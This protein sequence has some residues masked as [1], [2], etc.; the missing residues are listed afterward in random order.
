MINKIKKYFP[1]FLKKFLFYLYVTAVFIFRK[2]PAN[3]TIGLNLADAFTMSPQFIIGGRVK[4]LHL[5][6][7]F[8]DSK[9]KF[10]LLY[11]V[12]SVLSPYT[13]IWLKICKLFGVKVIWNQNGVAFPAWSGD[14]YE[15][16][17]HD[18]KKIH[19]ADFVIYQSEFCKLGADKYLGEYK[20]EYTVIHNCIDAEI[21]KPAERPL[22]LS[23]LVLLAIGTHMDKGRIILPLQ[24]TALLREKQIPVRLRIAGRFTWP[25][26]EAETIAEIKKLGIADLVDF[27]NQGF[28][29][30]Q[31]PAIYQSGHI[32]LHVKY[33]DPC[34]TAV[35]EAMGC[36]IPVIGSKTGGLPEL[37][38]DRA[39]VLINLPDS[40]EEL[41]YP[42]AEAIAAAVIK[43][44]TDW[45]AYSRNARQHVLANLNKEKWLA[46]HEETFQRILSK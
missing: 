43:I 6:E 18:I 10:N 35:I 41:L 16:I 34:P 3:K 44:S 24:V 42:S 36:G 5:R 7:H 40:W 13:L 20:G 31:A 29:Q 2:D 15:E 8:G 17:N 1:T 21:F 14:K 9:K 27:D 25:N 22:P 26:G 39:G 4:L 32:L 37:I 11:L 33:K 46:R 30:A 23:P 28:T 45:S 12:S 38:P 19:N